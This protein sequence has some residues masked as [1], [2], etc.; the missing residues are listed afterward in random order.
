MAGLLVVIGLLGYWAWRR[1]SNPADSP[2]AL[3]Q[4]PAGPWEETVPPPGRAVPRPDRPSAPAPH[5]SAL[6]GG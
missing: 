1:K 3:A 5:E 2:P 6:V 4:A